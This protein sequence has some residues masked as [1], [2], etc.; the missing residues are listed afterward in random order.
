MTAWVN[1][2]AYF[3]WPHACV[4]VRTN[5]EEDAGRWGVL[6]ISYNQLL[7]RSAQRNMKNQRW[8]VMMLVATIICLLSYGMAEMKK[9]MSVSAL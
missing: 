6:P 4:H 9:S 8:L 5:V 7:P 3:M 1:L 2:E